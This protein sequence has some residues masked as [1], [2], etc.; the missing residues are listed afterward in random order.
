VQIPTSFSTANHSVCLR[1]MHASGVSPLSFCR[2]LA[3]TRVAQKQ[4]A[5]L[6]HRSTGL[7][8]R[9]GWLDNFGKSTDAKKDEEYRRQQVGHPACPFPPFARGSAVANCP[10]KYLRAPHLARPLL[11]CRFPGLVGR[12]MGVY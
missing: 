8:V 2:A 4:R 6:W 7:S 1:A 11:R 5:A 9:S 3:P 10:S 12:T